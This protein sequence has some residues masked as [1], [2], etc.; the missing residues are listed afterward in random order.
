MA[1]I[2]LALVLF[3][4]ILGTGVAMY[5]LLHRDTPGVGPLGLLLLAA[6]MWSF[7]EG[8][9]LAANGLGSTVFWAKFRLS[10][11]TIIPLAWLLLTVEYTGNDRHITR[12]HLIAL[13]VEPIVFIAMVWTNGVHKLV[14][15]SRD[16]VFTAGGSGV[17][18]NRGIAFW[19]HVSYSYLLVALGAFL[20]VRLSMRTDQ[21]FRS[22]S[23]ALLAAITVPLLA[24]A[25]FLFQFTPPGIDPTGVAFV[26]TGTIITGAILRRQLLAVTAGT[27]EH[28]RDEIL[29]ELEDLVFIVD[30]RGV[31]VDCNQSALQALE[32]TADDV[33]GQQLATV[34]PS[35]T[36]PLPDDA[37][38]Y[39]RVEAVNLDGSVRKF[40]VQQSLIERPF[41]DSETRILSLRDVTD[42]TRREQQLDVLNRLLRHN[43]RNEMNVIRGH[44]ELLAEAADGPAVDRHLDRIFDTIDTVTERSDKVGTLTRA[45]DAAGPQ[46]VDLTLT[47][48]D[49]IGTVREAHPS[50]TIQFDPDEASGLRVNSGA[51][52][53]LA[54]EEL[55][56]N[57][58]E[59]NDGGPTV[60][61]GVDSDATGVTV[62]IADDGPGIGEQE[63]TVIER[64]RETPLAHSSGIGLW[65]VAWIVRTVGGTIR[66]ETT[67]DGT[68]VVV[69]LPRDGDSDH[70]ATER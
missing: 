28:G 69:R 13:L 53:G 66:F 50:A 17:V 4:G 1:V 64:G 65:L 18:A 15:Q 56:S 2:Y 19:G 24:N 8:L 57:A 37:T 43:L 30:T 11:S 70:A 5:A 34:A 47:L 59:H 27:R 39:H 62:R 21:L 14:W 25:A 46:S 38:E 51:S 20:L 40:D 60:T 44:A 22:Q 10:I 49:A 63:R 16:L 68:T 55:L 54:F 9:S 3:A 33:I 42:R 48:R 31:V 23:T 12:N 36:E 45:F 32:T 61:V 35:L 58:I 41:G 29:A 6:A 26:A 52:I 7:T 67:D